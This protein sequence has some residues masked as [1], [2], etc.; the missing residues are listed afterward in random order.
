MSKSTSS[1]YEKYDTI[2]KI[3]TKAEELER[4]GFGS[5][6]FVPKQDTDAG[7][8]AYRELMEELKNAENTD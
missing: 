1:Y 6:R 2:V 7:V 4:A 8:K 5:V 3:L